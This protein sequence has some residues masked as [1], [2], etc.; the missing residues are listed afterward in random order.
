M[1]PWLTPE[2]VKDLCHP[3]T[4]KAAQCAF[5]KSLGL[6]VKRKPDGSPLVMRS[7]LESTLGAVANPAAVST[8]RKGKWDPN[9]DALIARFQKKKG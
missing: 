6:T 2:E 3:L 7:D 4:Q 8:A 5:L 1:T 9:R